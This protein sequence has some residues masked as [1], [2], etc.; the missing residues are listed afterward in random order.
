MGA[1]PTPPFTLNQTHTDGGRSWK[2]DGSRWKRVY[3]LSGG[4]ITVSE[5]TPTGSYAGAIANVTGLRFDENSGFDLTDLGGGNAKVQMNSIFKHWKVNG[6][7]GLTA[8]GQD[9]ANFIAGSGVTIAAD[10]VNN[11]LT[12]SST[13]E[14]SAIKKDNGDSAPVNFVRCLTQF[15]YDSLTTKDVN[16]LYFIKQ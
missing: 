6:Q 9:T 3:E 7:P 1:F 14:Q 4:S 10:S 11:S 15:E 8:Q 12:F 5:V 13:V 16:T 2:W